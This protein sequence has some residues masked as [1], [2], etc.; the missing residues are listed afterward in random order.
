MKRLLWI[1]MLALP[2]WCSGQTVGTLHSLGGI[3]VERDA[4][5]N[6]ALHATADNSTL[7]NGLIAPTNAQTDAQVITASGSGGATKWAA[8]SGGG[9]SG[10]LTNL[11]TRGWTNNTGIYG[12]GVG[13]RKSTRLN[14]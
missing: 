5:V 8:A 12:N 1:G 10:G 3:V 6:G 13:D 9:T 2:L 11:D 4:T 7:W 14:S